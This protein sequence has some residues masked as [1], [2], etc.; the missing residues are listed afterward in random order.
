MDLQRASGR[1]RAAVR[2][3][4]TTGVERRGSGHPINAHECGASPN[5]GGLARSE[6]PTG[7][8]RATS[9]DPGGAGSMAA[10]PG[11]PWPTAFVGTVERPRRSRLWQDQLHPGVERP[12]TNGWR[13]A[14]A[15]SRRNATA[16]VR[17]RAARRGCPA[18]TR[19]GPAAGMAAGG[20]RRSTSAA[21]GRRRNSPPENRDRRAPVHRPQ[22][23]QVQGDPAGW[24]DRAT[25]TRAPIAAARLSSA[26]GSPPQSGHPAAGRRRSS[27]SAQLNQR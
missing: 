17:T 6:T 21:V 11:R 25:T 20:T 1:A 19:T 3:A 10:A 24:A 9:P 5:P 18:T 14:R 12:A 2:Q 22:T 16:G 15:F 4:A 7:P 8:L 26:A 23:A 27:Q 13:A